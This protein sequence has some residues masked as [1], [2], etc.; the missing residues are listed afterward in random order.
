[1]THK[2]RKIKKRKSKSCKLCKTHK[3]YGGSHQFWSPQQFK[4]TFTTPLTYRNRNNNWNSWNNEEQA[5][6]VPVPQHEGQAW[7]GHE[8]AY[9]GQG[10]EGQAYEGQGH[11]EEWNG[12]EGNENGNNEDEYED[13][14]YYDYNDDYINYVSLNLLSNTF[15]SLTLNEE[16]LNLN[17]GEEEHTHTCCTNPS[18]EDQLI[19][20]N[21]EIERIDENYEML[22]EN[23]ADTTVGEFGHTK[24]LSK[25]K[26]ANWLKNVTNR[27]KFG[28]QRLKNE[29][30]KQAFLYMLPSVD[31]T[32]KY[33]ILFEE[34][35]EDD[36]IRNILDQYLFKLA[37][38]L[39]TKANITYAV[40]NYS[41]ET[42][43][44]DY[45]RNL[46][47]LMNDGA[48][49]INRILKREWANFVDKPIEYS[50]YV[51]SGGNLILIITGVLC[52]LHKCWVNEYEYS[53][54]LLDCLRKDFD[55]YLDYTYDAFYE[56]LDSLFMDKKFCDITTE[57]ISQISD[58]DFIFMTDQD[59]YVY[60]IGVNPTTKMIN[61]LSAYII[62]NILVDSHEY[63][64]TQSEENVMANNLAPFA[65]KYDERWPNFK[66]IDF[67]GIDA[68]GKTRM[69]EFSK[70][71]FSGYRQTCNYIKELPIYLNRLKQGYLKYSDITEM[72]S[73]KSDIYTK[74]GECIDLS[75]GCKTNTL[76]NH[77]QEHYKRGSYYSIQNIIEEI[78]VIL[79]HA[80]DDKT[81]K[82]RSRL[83][84]LNAINNESIN[85]LF[86]LIRPIIEDE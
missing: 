28:Y 39:F 15:E 53:D 32:Q 9:E 36:I 37:T 26:S 76:Y 1:M 64:T 12:H 42:D 80:E 78:E 69:K 55:E 14:Q 50:C 84:F 10:H 19:N 33:K 58:L 30:L 73:S 52:Y 85:H 16:S 71:D 48:L 54:D 66:M 72:N 49:I 51:H 68:Y 61:D 6:E 44:F 27:G 2:N 77:K 82:R 70:G 81:A 17:E 38:S 11:E 29:D 22:L 25:H 43:N 74:Y 8:E 5:Y 86:S 18:L 63:N 7:N 24:Q 79:Q 57:L 40:S 60:N 45:L 34:N 67:T 62:R 35:D 4:P 21:Q 46:L 23:I 20:I 65:G 13:E 83:Y 3:K 75:I 56:W 31:I 41:L 47:A 59:D